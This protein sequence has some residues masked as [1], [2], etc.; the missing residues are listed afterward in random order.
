MWIEIVPDS[1][2]KTIKGSQP[3]RAVWIEIMFIGI[4]G[5]IYPVTACEGCVD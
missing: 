2:K 4:L 1:A 3:A 5:I